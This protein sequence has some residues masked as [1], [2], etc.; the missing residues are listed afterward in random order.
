M[1]RNPPPKE[2][3]MFLLFYILKTACSN[4]RVGR[5]PKGP[6]RYPRDTPGIPGIRAAPKG[7]NG[8]PRDPRSYPKDPRATHDPMALGSS[9][10]IRGLVHGL[11]GYSRDHTTT[12]VSKGYHKDH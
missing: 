5:L 4:Q 1:D 9:P 8:Y 10:G 11:N 7:S 3:I 6:N 2:L 12:Q